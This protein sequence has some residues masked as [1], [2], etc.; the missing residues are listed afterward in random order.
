[1]F[2]SEES[3]EERFDTTIDTTSDDSAITMG[4]PVTAA[5]ISDLVQI[6]T[7]QVGCL[8]VTCQLQEFLDQYPPKSTEKAFEHIYQI[9]QVLDKYLVDNLKQHQYCM[10]PDSEYITLIAYAITLGIDLCNFLAI[11]AVLSILLDTMSS[12]LQYIQYLQQ[13]FNDYY[14]THTQDVM[15][16]LEQQAIKIQA[17]MYDSMTKHNFDRVSGAVDRVSGTVDRDL[18]QVDTKSIKPTYD[19]DSDTNTDSI[20]H[21]QNTK[22]A[23]KDIDTQDNVQNTRHDNKV[24]HVKW[25]TETNQ[26]D[27]QYLRDYDNMHR[28]IED[29]QNEEYYK[30]QRQIHSTIMGDTPVRRAHNRQ[31]I[32]NISTYDSDL[33]RISKSVSHKLDLGQNSLLEA[34]QYTTVKAAAAMKAQNKAMKAQDK[35]IKVQDKAIKVQDK[36]DTPKVHMSDDNG[37]NKREIYRRAE[38]IIPHLDGTHNTPDSSDIDSHDYLDLVNIEI[39]QPNTRDQKKRQ[40]AAE[41]EIANIH[42]ANVE[43]IKPNTRGRKLRQKVPDDEVIDIDKIAKDDM[44]RYTIKQELKDILHAGKLAKEIERKLKENRKLQAEKARQLQIEKDLKEKEAKRCALEKA[45]ISA[46]IEKHRPCTPNTPNEINI[47]GTGINANIN[48]KEGTKNA[49]PPYKKATKASQIKSS[50]NEGTK[51]NKDMPDALLGDPIVNTKKN[52][53]KAKATGQTDNIDENDVQIYEFLF[54]G[55]PNPPDLEGVDEDRLFELQRNV[56]E[57]LCKR[58]EKRER[59]ITK[60]VKEFEKHLTL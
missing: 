37:Q 3:D 17:I 43:I 10:S 19:D 5:F 59:N 34:Q 33:Q 51:P 18:D 14:E 35:A 44:P 16:K 1:M 50:H 4:K 42:L 11:L 6:P 39:I 13:V 54:E 21:D 32:D 15:I 56:Q 24:T 30:A 49:Q 53:K 23:P 28:Q 26:I 7:E 40:K 41:A 60:R 20:K 25:S 45:K 57:Q 31:Y 58:D 47:P 8:Q 22:G 38:Y 48:D 27:N 9:L 52:T 55:L 2:N 46:L 36:E 12:D 29:K